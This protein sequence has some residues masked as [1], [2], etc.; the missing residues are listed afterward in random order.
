MK[1]TTGKIINSHIE[2]SLSKSR[3]KP[4]LLE[5]VSLN[6]KAIC[7]A[8]QNLQI[9]INTTIYKVGAEIKEAFSYRSIISRR[10]D[11]FA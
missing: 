8:R 6:T 7:S 2:S 9:A 10:Y 3:F 4:E 1:E 5:V 11:R